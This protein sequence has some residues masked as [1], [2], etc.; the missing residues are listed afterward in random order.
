[1]KHILRY[2]FGVVYFILTLFFSLLVFILYFIWTFKVMSYSVVF[3][4]E[5]IDNVYYDTSLKETFER[6][7]KFGKYK[8]K[9]KANLF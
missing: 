7:I 5:N 3:S 1:M 4:N 9:V 6:C 8:N 2:P